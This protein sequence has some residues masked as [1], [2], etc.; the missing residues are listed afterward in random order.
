MVARIYPVP[1]QWRRVATALAA[2]ALATAGKLV[3]GGIPVAIAL[4]LAYPLALLV[5]GFTTSAERR[6]A[7]EPVTR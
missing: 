7:R 6:R 2:V 4:T 3:G 1:Y 5:L